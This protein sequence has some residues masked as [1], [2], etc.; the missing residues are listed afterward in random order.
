MKYNNNKYDSTRCQCSEPVQTTKHLLLGCPLYK[1][2]RERAGIGRE[3]ILQSLLF[4]PN[5]TAALIDFI[6]ETRVATR[7]WLQPEKA[8]RKILGGG[9]VYRR[10]RREMER[11][12]VNG[13]TII[14]YF[15]VF[16]CYSH[17]WKSFITISFVF[18]FPFAFNF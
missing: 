8:T 12:W 5:G 6:Q 4:T 1:A 16:I 9:G 7:R 10:R 18:S 2:E 17:Y 15:A 11:R 3:T 13:G 14:F